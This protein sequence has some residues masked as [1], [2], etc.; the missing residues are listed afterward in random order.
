MQSNAPA[1]VRAEHRNKWYQSVWFNALWTLLVPTAFFVAME[2][3]H[4]GTLLGDDFWPQRLAPHPQAF[5]LGWLFAVGVYVLLSQAFG[6]HWP[7]SLA[8][9]V[10][11]YLLGIVNY[12]KLQMR[13]EPLLPWDF[14]QIG[15]FMGVAGS[16]HL[17][18]EPQMVVVGVLMLGVVIAGVF[19][20]MP[21]APRH[22]RRRR[23]ALACAGAALSAG[24]FF[25]I[26]MNEDMCK[27][28]NIYTDMWM[29]DRY[30]KN[31]GI[32]TGFLTN[33]RVL[34]LDAPQEYSQE[35]V[36]AI[37]ARTQS[38][39]RRKGPVYEDSYAARTDAADVEKTPNIIYLMNESFWD[40]SR[41]SGVEFDRELT[42]NL[43]ALMEEG[44]YG[45]V[46]SPSFGGGTCD[47]EFEALTGF[48]LERLPAGSK[49]YQQYVTRDM[50]ALP[51]YLKQAG[52]Q[53]LAIHGYYARMWSRNTAYPHLGIDEFISIEDMSSPEKRRGFVSDHE[54]TQQI[55]E[56]YESRRE[57]G[58]L[59]IHAVTMQNHTT[60]SAGR[61]PDEETVKVVSDPGFTQSTID[62]LQD[63][64]TGVHEADKALGELV[65]YFRNVDEPTIIVFWGDHYNPLGTGYEV[66]E[67]TGTIEK[68]DTA[69]PA[70]HQTDLLIWSNYGAGAVD[71]GTVAAYELSPVVLDLYGLEKPLYFEYLTQQ[72]TD[73]YRARTR[74]VTVETDG[75]FS[76]ELS[77]EQQAWFD[78]HWMLQYDQMFGEDYT[79]VF[80]A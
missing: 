43:H 25:G 30:Y 57:D 68:G 33:L 58:P 54:M 42:P 23:A 15:D 37:L 53:T 80:C 62:Q 5:V 24:I 46:Y 59:F 45:R 56:Q 4:R 70:L 14:T 2:W 67:K 63:F 17:A 75:T 55:I 32:I 79:A 13:G 26:Y 41:L 48:S 44:A 74:G 76:S 12:F 77:Q 47:V 78:D 18:V 72:L 39:A 20:K 8:L 73:G 3:L 69:S 52:Y 38:A 49:P 51:Q 27:R 10:V 22:A 31:Y 60:Y 28:F 29:Q 11:A 16:V 36:D 64:A 66:F 6:R 40:V 61:Y 35:N 71:L 50:A 19:V 7:A 9:G 65:E 34:D 1:L 21:R